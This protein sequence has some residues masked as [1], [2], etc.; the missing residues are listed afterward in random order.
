MT[1]SNLQKTSVILDCDPGVDDIA[2]IFLALS[3]EKIDL[4]GVTVVAGNVPV[5]DTFWNARAALAL[6]G[7]SDI[8]VFRGCKKPLIREQVFGRH[9]HIGR[10]DNIFEASSAPTETMHAV[11]FIGKEACR[12]RRGINGLTLCVTGPFT[13]I[14]TMLSRY[15]DAVGGIDAVIC[16]GGAFRA[17]GLRTPWAEFNIFADPDAAKQVMN[18]SVPVTLLPLD[19]TFKILVSSAEMSTLL[20]KGGKVSRGLVSLMRL[21]NRE[22]VRRYGA[23]GSVMHDPAV[24]GFV[25]WPELYGEKVHT[26]IGVV[27]SGEVIGHTYADFFPSRSVAVSSCIIDNI[28]EDEFQKRMLER[29]IAMDGCLK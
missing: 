20:E 5:D 12:R 18:A 23:A 6:A 21:S 16:M 28:D 3:S 10:F 14:A 9:A 29:L 26:E 7:R 27:C 25:L 11:D 22:D 24:I 1:R 15:P 13:N 19:L 2:G 8:P 17:L 4:L